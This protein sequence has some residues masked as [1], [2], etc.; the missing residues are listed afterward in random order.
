MTAMMEFSVWLLSAVADFLGQEPVIYLY[1]VI[2]FLFI[3]R[4]I[5]S[6]T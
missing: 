1:G 5:K 4:V 6:L 3:C 2:L